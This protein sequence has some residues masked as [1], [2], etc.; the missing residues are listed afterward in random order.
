MW[1]PYVTKVEFRLRQANVPYETAAGS[2]RNAPKGKIPYIEL[3]G[4]DAEM[5][6]TQIGDS[7]IIIKELANSN[8]VPDLNAKL[9][10]VDKAQDAALIALMEDKMYFFNVCHP[11]FWHQQG[12]QKAE[13]KQMYERWIENYY[14]QRDKALWA[15]PYPMRILV[16]LMVHRNIVQTLHG[17]GT[18]RHSAAEIDAFKRDI[19]EILDQMLQER[20][21]ASIRRGSSEPFWCLGG[22]S[23]TDA[24]AVLFAFVNSA[25]LAKRYVVLCPSYTNGTIPARVVPQS[26]TQTCTLMA[27]QTVV[28]R[29]Q[30]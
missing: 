23:P 15:V 3:I 29:L 20:L 24:D 12:A 17:Q 14:T 13:L 2:P 6:K 1:S 19:W 8:L 9:S 22:D 25:L 27:V 18:S 26:S 28:R 30:S 4:N 10:A 5:T 16:G 7:A 21:S 11:E